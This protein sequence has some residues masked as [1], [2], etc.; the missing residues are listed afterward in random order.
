MP[1][2]KSKSTKKPAPRSKPLKM[3]G[4]FDDLIR[5]SL[6]VKKPKGGRPKARGTS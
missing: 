1:D 2:K 5:K 3:A 6:T 4:T